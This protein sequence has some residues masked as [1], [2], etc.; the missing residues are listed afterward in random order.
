MPSSFSTQVT[1]QLGL[2]YEE[3]APSPAVRAKLHGLLSKIDRQ[4]GAP[5]WSALVSSRAG[6]LSNMAVGGSEFLPF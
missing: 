2:D 3:V 4:A 5:A 1:G 6:P